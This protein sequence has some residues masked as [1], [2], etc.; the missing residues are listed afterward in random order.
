MTLQSHFSTGDFLDVAEEAHP[1]L[2]CLANS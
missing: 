2:G 1:R